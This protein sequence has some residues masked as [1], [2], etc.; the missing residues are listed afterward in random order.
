MKIAGLALVVI[1]GTMELLFVLGK[2]GGAAIPPLSFTLAAALVLTGWRCIQAAKAASACA[3]QTHPA[4]AASP[5]EGTAV[6]PSTRVLPLTAE[7]SA[8]LDRKLAR[9]QRVMFFI[10]S[11]F[12]AAFLIAGIGIDA[13]GNNNAVQALPIM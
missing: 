13:A 12:A 3:G 6:F 5:G 8:L 2:I 7:M 10:G 1:G 11:G 4:A 9:G